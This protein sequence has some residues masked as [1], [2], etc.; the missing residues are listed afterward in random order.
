MASWDA[1]A[2][3]LDSSGSRHYVRK[4]CSEGD[5]ICARCGSENE[6]GVRICGSCGSSVERRCSTCGANVPLDFAYCGVCGARADERP[7]TPAQ[8]S[9]RRTV[10]ALFADLSGY[11]RLA[12]QL[13]PEDLTALL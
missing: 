12:E 3:F 11:T 8:R 1:A 6:A 7:A 9:D 2:G 10:T 5:V 13:D 4:V